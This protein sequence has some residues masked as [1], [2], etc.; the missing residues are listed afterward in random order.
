MQLSKRLQA[1]AGM[2]DPGSRLADIGTDHGYIPI[3]LV[4]NG[5]I[6]S[7][8]AMDIHEGPL[9]KANI[10]IEEAGLNGKIITRLSDGLEGLRPGEADTVLIA[11]MGGALMSRIL[12]E[13]EAILQSVSGL[14]LQP[15]SEIREFRHFLHE[16]AYRITAEHMLIDDG[17]Y[18]VIL[19]A[20]HGREK[21]ASE[22][23]YLYGSL[24]LHARDSVLLQYIQKK[25]KTYTSI[26][27]N[28]SGCENEKA[29]LRRQ[30]L[31][32]LLNYGKEAL[33]YYEMQ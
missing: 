12:A 30:E 33:S 23:E 21:Y 3:Y 20:V 14:I 32:V 27:K 17:K 13:G 24:L 25:Q 29:L 9:Q 11:G 2:I 19:K 6:P 28:L 1:L 4:Q 15:Q 16:H 31:L 22:V 7:A 5:I 26:L 18:Y 8:V 10:H